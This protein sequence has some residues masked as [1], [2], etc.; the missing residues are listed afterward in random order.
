VP[1]G[2]QAWFSLSFVE[3]GV[4]DAITGDFSDEVQRPDA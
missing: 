3:N 4:A 1:A 2:S